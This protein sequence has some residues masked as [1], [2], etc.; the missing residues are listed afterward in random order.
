MDTPQVQVGGPEVI[1]VPEST[2]NTEAPDVE[3]KGSQNA[4]NESQADNTQDITLPDAQPSSSEPKPAE[5][6]AAPPPPKKKPGLHFLDYL[7]S[8]IVELAVGQGD[9][10]TLLTAHQSLLLESPLLGEAVAAFGESGHRRI[11]LPDEDVEAFGCFLQFQYTHEYSASH[12]DSSADQDAVIGEIDDSGEKLLKHA[13]VYTLAEKL[14]MPALKTLAHSKIH[15]INSTS[16]GEIAYARYVY[17]HTPIDDVTIRKPVASFWAT[18]SH[19]LRHEAEQEF[20]KLCLEVPEFC[21]DVLSLVLDQKEK[22][23]QD[24]AETESGVK[25]SGRKRLRS[26]I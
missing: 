15:R 21:F 9:N 26:G 25:G 3:M 7:T 1:P 2:Q 14:G 8:P 12:S 11:E 4:V 24:R 5:A 20:K 6:A 22:R 17:T 19:V 16:H 13:R 18:R 10:K 23:A